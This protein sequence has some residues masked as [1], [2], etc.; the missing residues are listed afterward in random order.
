MDRIA[1]ARMKGFTLVCATC[2][3]LRDGEDRRLDGCTAAAEKIDCRGPFG[4]GIYAHYDGPLRSPD[5]QFVSCCFV[6]G[7][8]PVGAVRP[9]RVEGSPLFGVCQK[10]LD[11][12]G[13]VTKPGERPHALDHIDAPTIK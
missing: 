2:K 7:E 13:W 6:C 10:H 8:P 9:A 11:E 4:L 3:R 1:I 12:M 5:G